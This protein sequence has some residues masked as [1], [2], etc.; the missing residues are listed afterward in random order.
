[1]NILTDD[2]VPASD[3]APQNFTGKFTKLLT[4]WRRLHVEADSM[5]NGESDAVD[6]AKKL[7]A[8]DAAVFL[9]KHAK[10][11]RK[12]EPVRGYSWSCRYCS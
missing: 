10:P 5:E 2:N 9:A 1:L 12:N 7:A 4:V 11:D 6:L 8:P 3:A